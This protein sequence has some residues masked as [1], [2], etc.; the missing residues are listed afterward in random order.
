VLLLA[1]AG[2]VIGRGW[3]RGL[4]LAA[5]IVLGTQTYL[6]SSWSEWQF[7]ASYGHRAFTDV[8]G[9]TAPFLAAFFERVAARPLASRF[10]AAGAAAA[11]LLSVAQMIQYWIGILPYANTTWA[12][13]RT[14]FLRFQ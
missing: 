8:L 10:V 14:L 2:M 4:R 7:G 13:Y 9:L 11:V 6:I 12:Q 3:V 5:V 1:V